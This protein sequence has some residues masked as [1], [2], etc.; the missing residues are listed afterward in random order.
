M[1]MRRMLL[2]DWILLLGAM[3]ALA[4]PSNATAAP[5]ANK[6][7]KRFAAPPAA[8][9][10]WV[11]WFWSA[12][13][14]TREGITADLEAMAR[15]GI[16]G[17]LIMEVD[18]SIPAGPAIYL[19]PQWLELYKYMIKEAERLKI[20]VN[21]NNDGGWCGSGGPWIKP[22]Q[23]MQALTW[24]ET[25]MA[26]PRKFS[27][28]LGQPQN[29]KD[30]YQDIAVLAFPA[31]ADESVRMADCSPKVTI[32]QGG[33]G[34][35]PTKLID[36]SPAT[37]L[38]LPITP[39][40]KPQFIQLEFPKPFTAC[41]VT[42]TIKDLE[43]WLMSHRAAVQTSEDGKQFKTLREFDVPWPYG[44]F[45]FDKVSARY[46]RILFPFTP[47]YGQLAPAEIE[48]HSS[49]RIEGI[50]GKAGFIS[51]AT[52]AQKRGAAPTPESTVRQNRVI[53]LTGQMDKQ[54][55]LTWDVPEGRWVV[56]R[57]GHTSTGKMNHPAPA[58]SLGLECDK[59]SKEAIEAHF[60]GLIG[61][62]LKESKSKALTMTHIDSWEVGSQ[63][64]SPRF[65]ED[66]KKR[67]GYDPV[68]L[69]PVLTGRTIGDQ[70]VTERFLWDMRRTISDLVQEN[71]AGQ[72]RKISNE[73]G[74]KLSIEAYG[75]VTIDT[76]AYAGQADVPMGEFWVSTG[77]IPLCKAMA[78]S[79]HVYGRPV[80]GAEA[81]TSEAGLA[82]WQNHPYTLKPLGD[83]L[84]CEGINRFVFHR[85]AMQPWL[86][87]KPGMTMGP[88]GVHYERTETW[89]EQ[90]KPWHEYLSR[91]QYMLQQGNFVADFAYFYG[92]QAPNDLPVRESLNPVPPAGYDFDGCA[93]E[94]VIE[95]M[96]VKDG[97]LEVKGGMNYRLL[98]LPQQGDTMTP[99]LLRK[100]RELVKDGATVVV[101]SRPVKSPSLRDYPKCDKEI[102]KMAEEVWGDCDGKTV[103]EHR[104]GK[105][106]VIW[107][108]PLETILREL[109]ARPDF[110]AQSGTGTPSLRYIHRNID[111]VDA[112]FVSNPNAW[113]E[114]AVCTFR[115]KGSRPELWWP[116]TGR[117]EGV[118]VY[119]ESAKGTRM[120][121]RLGPCGSVFVVFRSE[122]KD[123][124][125]RVTSVS[126]NGQMMLVAGP[127]PESAQAGVNN[128]NI[129]GTFTM[130][131]WVK[132]AADTLLPKEEAW[133]IAGLVPG[134]NDAIYPA[135]GHEVYTQKEQA[136][137]GV[138]VGKNGVCVCEHGDSHYPP[139]LVHPAP[140]SGWTHVAVVYNGGTP[141]LYINGKFARKGL[142]STKNVHPG[143]GVRHNRPASSFNGEMC[144]A[145]QFGRALGEAE[146]TELMAATVPG[147]EGISVK[148]NG[149]ALKVQ[150]WQAGSYEIKTAHGRDL[151]F[152][153]PALPSPIEVQGPWDLSFPK[154]WGAPER[155]TL[156]KLASWTANSNTGVKYFSGTATYAKKLNVPAEVLGKGRRLELDL[157]NVLVIAEVKLNGK[158]LGI[159]WKP[160][161]R[162]DVTKAVKAGENALEV[163]VTNLWT[164]RLIGD[165]QLPEDC[166]W[167]TQVDQG[168]GSLKAWPKWMVEHTPRTSG[169]LTFATW[170]HYK[171]DSPLLESGMLGPVTLRPSAV[172]SLKL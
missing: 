120:P 133:G 152:E 99:A 66:F 37:S 144:A 170:K 72:M 97:R 57:M 142:K 122:T 124:S 46:Y 20:E 105:G 68:P 88:W 52:A 87:L 134:N 3:F 106:K 70:E 161:F 104:F 19:S 29:I 169:R 109:H 61:R 82:K 98:I 123:S 23:S 33:E 65:R 110:S 165:E 10:P 73:H 76:L 148:S 58:G 163:Q 84:F 51:D 28:S 12:G 147:Q 78:S 42:I 107:G 115:V 17:V 117:T 13:N 131:L 113:T 4:A 81:F 91:C 21:M 135:P 64:W 116:D 118:A 50:A 101:G 119:E 41:A 15:V 39:A 2:P 121:L 47:N 54:G 114:D 171:K 45:N 146:L 89:W 25:A 71:Y 22:E 155:I 79:G 141:S 60:E 156:E 40:D 67:R 164:N 44:S 35:D 102:K 85:Y 136:C 83:R 34:M 55:H 53:N 166:E 96:S 38:T 140:I 128:Q 92:E 63:N 127:S 150:A 162:V 151:K 153:V 138:A 111:G 26:G 95:R 154:G 143:L 1:R 90:T 14:V 69:L 36:G 172:L 5:D 49:A 18:Q 31:P 30:Y 7:A 86:D 112:Y 130:A 137:A 32:G 94:A 157:G 93:A 56:L 24:S 126:R 168:Y 149:K 167:V 75:N 160:P 132:P 158:N 100:I 145:R 27:G 108:K 48:L 9:K 16:G 125:A 59:L 62:L 103:L 129:A 8:A 74:L 159:L 139:V 11:Y 77:C 6:L 80:I 43:N